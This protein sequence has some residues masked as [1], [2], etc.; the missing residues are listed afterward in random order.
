MSNPEN[1]PKSLVASVASGDNLT[2]HILTA[3]GL[4]G[5]FSVVSIWLLQT[6]AHVGVPADVAQG[7][8]LICI[9]PASLILQKLPVQ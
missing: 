4:A 8:T 2:G 3:A 5:A 9:I 1:Q 6:F 7:W